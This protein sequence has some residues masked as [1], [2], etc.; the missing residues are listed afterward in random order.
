MLTSCDLRGRACATL[1]QT[2]E[3]GSVRSTHLLFAPKQYRPSKLVCPAALLATSGGLVIGD[4]DD[5]ASLSSMLARA[6]G[7]VRRV[8]D[9]GGRLISQVPLVR[10]EDGAWVELTWPYA[11]AWQVADAAGA[12]AWLRENGIA[13]ERLAAGG[14]Y[15]HEA[16][17]DG[18]RHWLL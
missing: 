6:I 1:Q 10:G 4:A 11:L 8:A 7:E 9:G 15:S 16:I 13:V 12:A 18:A 5:V 14:A 17:L 3:K 2:H